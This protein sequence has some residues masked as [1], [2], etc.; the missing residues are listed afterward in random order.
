L[1][2]A[3]LIARRKSSAA[4]TGLLQLRSAANISRLEAANS[5]LKGFLRVLKACQIDI[6]PGI[7]R[8]A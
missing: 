6:P 1:A 5:R 4:C 7:R 8:Q 3:R 2:G